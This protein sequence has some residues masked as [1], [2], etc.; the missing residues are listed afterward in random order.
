MDTLAGLV[1][2]QM[3]VQLQLVWKFIPWTSLPTVGKSGSIAG[4]LLGKRNSVD[5][6]MDTSMYSNQSEITS[7]PV[8]VIV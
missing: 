2:N 1:R 5:L 8:H 3:S 4:I 7:L 6:E